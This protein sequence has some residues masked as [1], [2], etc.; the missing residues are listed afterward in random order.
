M[1]APHP[2]GP[3]LYDKIYEIFTTHKSFW[4]DE[5]VLKLHGG[6]GCTMM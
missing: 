6:D 3:N 4:D 1:K 5:N 2:K